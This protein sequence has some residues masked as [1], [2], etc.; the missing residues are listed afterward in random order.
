MSEVEKWQC[1]YCGTMIVSGITHICSF[2]CKP[3]YHPEHGMSDKKTQDFDIGISVK[4]ENSFTVSAPPTVPE[5]LQESAETYRLRKEVYGNN[6]KKFGHVMMA[7]KIDFKISR[8]DEWNRLGIF[9]QMVSKL[10]RYSENW[11]K[12]GHDDSLN[13]LAVYATMLRELDRQYDDIPF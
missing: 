12:G 6:Y 13:D 8:T 4:D 3:Y 9:V 11:N 5:M 1:N 7:L 2:N 10:T